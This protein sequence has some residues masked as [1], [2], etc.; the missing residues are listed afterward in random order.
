MVLRRGGGDNPDRPVL[1]TFDEFVS[2]ACK[3]D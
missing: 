1:Q 2:S 3:D